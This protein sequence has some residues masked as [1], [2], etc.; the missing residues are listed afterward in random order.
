MNKNFSYGLFLLLISHGLQ[1]QVADSAR[2]WNLGECIQY[3]RLHNIQ[4][5]LGTLDRESTLLDQVAA[6]GARE[7]SLSGLTLSFSCAACC[8]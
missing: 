1:A 6:R 5:R 3:A 4:I 8:Q 2:R 7:P